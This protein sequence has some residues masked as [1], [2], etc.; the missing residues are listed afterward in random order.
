MNICSPI[1][2]HYAPFS[3]TCGVHNMF[4]IDRNK[5]LVNFT[6]SNLLRLQKRNH[7]SERTVGGVWY[8]R[9]HCLNL[10]HNAEKFAARTAPDNC[11]HSTEHTTWLIS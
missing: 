8:Q 7:A 2:K 10:S 1:R 11:P 3:D 9:V 4:T 6:G 5:S